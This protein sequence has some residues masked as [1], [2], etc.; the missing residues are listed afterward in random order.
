MMHN[1]CI[2]L[3][4]KKSAFDLGSFF[5]V[6]ESGCPMFVTSSQCI[7]VKSIYIWLK[8]SRVLC[9]TELFSILLYMDRNMHTF[10]LGIL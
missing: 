7:A 3:V 5:C 10:D 2:L 9:I 1:D 4:T 6:G 8:C